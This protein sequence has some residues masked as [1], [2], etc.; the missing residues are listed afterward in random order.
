MSLYEIISLV[1]GFLD[2][3][4][5]LISFFLSAYAT[6]LEAPPVPKISALL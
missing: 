4:F 3:N 5:T 6:A 2:T 1:A